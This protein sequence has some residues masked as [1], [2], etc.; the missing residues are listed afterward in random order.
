MY[1]QIRLLEIPRIRFAHVYESSHYQVDFPIQPRLLECTFF[2]KGEAVVRYADGR[3]EHIP[4]GSARL[5]RFEEPFGISSRSA[6][7]RH[8]TVGFEALYTVE[9]GMP[10]TSAAKGAYGMDEKPSRAEGLTV[11][12]PADG[13]LTGAAEGV[14]KQ[15]RRLVATHGVQGMAGQLAG[16]GQLFELLA[17]FT[18]GTERTVLLFGRDLSPSGVLYAQRAV[19]Y[20]AAHLAEKISLRDIARELQ[21]GPAYLSTIFKSYTGSSVVSYI[22]ARRV[23]RIQELLA[24]RRMR[25][26]EAGKSV[27]LEDENYTSRLFKQVTGM[28]ARDYQ[29]L[30]AFTV[31]EEPDR[32]AEADL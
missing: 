8:I 23:E 4:E 10:D 29:R 32:P 20:I 2:E 22:Q 18:E 21:I 24:T 3:E 15:L 9:A 17:A 12:C 6:L 13:L 27:G 25:L 30:Y 11:L 28:P 5:S 7:C 16:V 1:Q 14:Q 26:G 31:R 19:R